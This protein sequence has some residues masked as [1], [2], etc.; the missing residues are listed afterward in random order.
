MLDS[1]C[2]TLGDTAL[3]RH[4]LAV[5]PAN[6]AEA[7]QRGQGIKKLSH[8]EPPPTPAKSERWK[9]VKLK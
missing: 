1:F 4:L 2:S 8:R 5:Q 7:I 3:Q 6:L 9:K